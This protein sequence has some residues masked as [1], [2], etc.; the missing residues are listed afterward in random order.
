MHFK[1]PIS[2]TF[3]LGVAFIAGC[4]GTPNGDILSSTVIPETQNPATSHL[5]EIASPGALVTDT[6]RL[7]RTATTSPSEAQTLDLTSLPAMRVAFMRP[8]PDNP[9]GVRGE[10]WVMDADGSDQRP[11]AHYQPGSTLGELGAFSPDGCLF[12]VTDA[13]QGVVFDMQTGEKVI[14]DEVGSA[15]PVVISNFAWSPDNTALTYYRGSDPSAPQTVAQLQRI[16]RLVDG[17]WSKPETIALNPSGGVILPVRVLEDGRVLT[18]M[19]GAG[20][21]FMSVSY[22][23]DLTSGTTQRLTLAGSGKMAN[24]FD[25]TP[26]GRVVFGIATGPV[27][28]WEMGTPPGPNAPWD[29]NLYVGQITASGVITDIVTLAPP[30]EESFA[31][32][33]KFTPDETGVLAVT[34][35][36][37][38][39][40][41]LEYGL[42][43]LPSDGTTR[44]SSLLSPRPTTHNPRPEI[45]GYSPLGSHYAVL[46][47]VSGSTMEEGEIWLVALDGS[48][49]APLTPGLWP[50]ALPVCEK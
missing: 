46:S 24:V 49:A 31:L 25:V 43:S 8:N 44:Y 48:V 11:A 18:Q 5:T 17:S 37:K 26:L 12:A 21:G 23:T 45:L 47:V 35:H 32:S 20:V 33:G 40:G 42:F 6:P 9:W 30:Q 4:A 14:I 27:G 1:S 15:E 28:P 2:W 36:G 3:L 38:S 19:Y 34:M 41:P 50:V 22:V 39:F 10:L 29:P 7:T 16:K 13:G